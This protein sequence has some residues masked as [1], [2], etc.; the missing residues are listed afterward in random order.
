VALIVFILVAS[1]S[2]AIP[3]LYYLAAGEG[4]R[5]TL[6]GWKAWL[7]ANNATV[8][9]VLLVVLGFVLI[10]QGISALSF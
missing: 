3:V 7:L 6:D 2:V 10:G 1:L 5:K 4:A 8:M 9:A